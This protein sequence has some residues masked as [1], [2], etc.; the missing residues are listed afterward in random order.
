MKDALLYMVYRATDP[1]K[2]NA[3]PSNPTITILEN[4][5]NANN[6]TTARRR[7]A[8]SLHGRRRHERRS[9]RPPS[10]HDPLEPRPPA[11]V[12]GRLQALLQARVGRQA[13]GRDFWRLR[14]LVRADCFCL[15][16]AGI[17]FFFFECQYDSGYP[18]R[19]YGKRAECQALEVL[20]FS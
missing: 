6:N 7:P 3:V 12:Q 16:L 15:I 11:A 17:F 18:N 13:Q 4:S 9:S 19:Y 8:R 1:A 20:G 14:A 2:V 10:R 5:T